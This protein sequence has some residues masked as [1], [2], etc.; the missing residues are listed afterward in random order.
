MLLVQEAQAKAYRQWNF[1]AGNLDDGENIVVGAI[2]ETK[3]ETGYDVQPESLAMINSPSGDSPLFF[4]F[5]MRVVSGEIA[6]DESEILDVKWV[7]L[8]QVKELDL[9]RGI[10]Q[11][12]DEILL[13][14]AAKKSY[15][16]DVIK[17]LAI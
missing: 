14:H 5:N 1:P 10:K 12:I 6:F 17:D 8:K 3:E 9:R 4:L 11:F 7:S 16:L 15:S 2:R 13:Q